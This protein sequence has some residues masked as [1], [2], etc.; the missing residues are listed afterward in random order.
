LA[1]DLTELIAQL[2]AVGGDT[3]AIEVK[4]AAG[5]LPESMSQSLSALSNLPGGGLIIL[6]V[7]EKTGFR[8]VPLA[9]PQVLKQGLAAKARTCTP[10]VR[11]TIDDAIVD[12]VMV[13]AARVHECDTSAKPCR[14]SATGAAYLR[15]YD[16][17]YRLSDLEEQAFLAQRHPPLF[18]R[19]PVAGSTQDDLDPD[20]VQGFLA[21]VRDLDPGGLGRFERDGE[22]LC[23][24]GVTTGEQVPTV[25]GL[26]ALGLHPQ[27]WF[28]RWVIQ[29]AADPL[30]GDPPGARA[31][32]QAVFSGPIPRMLQ[33][34]MQWARRNFDTVIVSAPDGSVRDQPVYP[35]TAFRELIA[36]ALIHRDLD[37]W[38]AGRAIEVRFRRD[39]LVINNPGGLYGITVDRLGLETVTSARNQRLVTICQFVQSPGTGSRVVEALATGIPTVTAELAAAGL[40]PA[41]YADSGIAFTVILRPSATAVVRG[42]GFN[43]TELRI[44]DALA[45]GQ[46]STAELH[47]LLGL[48]AANLRKALRTLRGRGLVEQI[49]GRGQ[50]TWYRRA[51]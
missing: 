7:D 20:L 9:N 17:D 13:I 48:S 29:V 21:T 44:Y 41:R 34:A 27:Q 36:N 2:R 23:R 42:G 8:P 39:R 14:L 18:D 3:T 31:R 12:G 38:S 51:D 1:E 50:P 30:P 47:S 28:P 46:R 4:S 5:G 35:L 15:A 11:L 40:P 16:G 26:L 24:A 45:G 22:L 10:P 43:E 25:A 19:A 49:G 37:H 33:Q 32:N 6:G